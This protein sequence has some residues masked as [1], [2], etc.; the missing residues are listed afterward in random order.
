MFLKTPSNPKGSEQLGSQ[1]FSASGF[2]PPSLQ[3]PWIPHSTY[4]LLASAS[5]LSFMCLPQSPL[6]EESFSH[7][8]A[9]LSLYLSRIPKDQRSFSLVV[10]AE[11]S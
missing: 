9:T 6:L 5:L 7:P 10:Q 3:T 4:C 1:Q 2:M 8:L 11:N